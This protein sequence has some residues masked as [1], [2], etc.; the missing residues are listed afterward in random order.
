MDIHGEVLIDVVDSGAAEDLGVF[1]SRIRSEGDYESSCLVM[2][3]SDVDHV[4]RC[5]RCISLLKR[6]GFVG[7]PIR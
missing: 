5:D 1:N 4:H 2:G 7:G 3:L 6:A